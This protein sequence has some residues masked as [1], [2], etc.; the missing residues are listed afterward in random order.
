M[1]D[2][3]WHDEAMMLAEEWAAL[4][5]L[6]GQGYAQGLKL[7]DA[8]IA[9]AAHLRTRPSEDKPTSAP[10]Q[11]PQCGEYSMSA[12]A[13]QGLFGV[14]S[15][16]PAAPDGP[17]GAEFTAPLPVAQGE[18]EAFEAWHRVEFPNDLM[19]RDS[20]YGYKRDQIRNRWIGW[21]AARATAPKLR[22]ALAELVAAYS[23]MLSAIGSPD[24]TAANERDAETRFERAIAVARAVLAAA[25]KDKP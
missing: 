2:Q 8:R 9:L 21:Q 24:A 3:Q 19:N 16:L 5:N 13:A 25:A 23:G 14:Q 4:A 17:A 10:G 18:R 15:F 1:T 20:L 6:L 12:R 11:C 22:E 7:P